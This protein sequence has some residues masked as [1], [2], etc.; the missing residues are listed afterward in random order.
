MVGRRR[1]AARAG[2]R[3]RLRRRGADRRACVR[4]W[5]RRAQFHRRIACAR[6]PLPRH[7]TLA[8]SRSRLR[9]TPG[10]SLVRGIRNRAASL[11]HP[12]LR[13][14]SIRESWTW[15]GAWPS[16]KAGN[17]VLRHTLAAV[18]RVSAQLSRSGD[19]S[20]MPIFCCARAIA[21]APS[22][23]SPWSV[24]E[25]WSARPAPWPHGAGA[26]RRPL[27]AF[28]SRGQPARKRSPPARK[29]LTRGIGATR[30]GGQAGSRQVRSACL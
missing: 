2:S 12:M 14:R 27:P 7:V 23:C 15:A 26:H 4:T 24:R 3:P 18:L 17:A 6:R 20:W 30:R 29:S 19:F 1:P 8:G 9:A 22:R 25:Q 11:N 10:R 21:P 28:S 13:A 5:G 16:R